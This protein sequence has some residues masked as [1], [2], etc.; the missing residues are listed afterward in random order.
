MVM[1]VHNQHKIYS[2]HRFV[3][4]CG[5]NILGHFII[6]VPHAN[7]NIADAFIMLQPQA[8]GISGLFYHHGPFK[9]RLW[10]HDVELRRHNVDYA[11]I[12]TEKNEMLCNDTI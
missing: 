8:N 2:K 7:N 6:S 5:N 4:L 10:C 12:Y 1:Y 11:Q 9:L 3:L